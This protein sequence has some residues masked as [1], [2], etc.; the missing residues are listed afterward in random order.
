[1]WN[2][3]RVEI[4]TG[5]NYWNFRVIMLNDASSKLFIY[6]TFIFHKTIQKSLNQEQMFSFLKEM[7]RKKTPEDYFTNNLS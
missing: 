7:Q 3:N 5:L 1:M 6:F 2:W 4:K